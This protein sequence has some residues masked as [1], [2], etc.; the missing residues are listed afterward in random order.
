MI[1]KNFHKKSEI[2][3]FMRLRIFKWVKYNGYFK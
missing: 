3:L 1:L 2:G